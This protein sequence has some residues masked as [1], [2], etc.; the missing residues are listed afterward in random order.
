MFHYIN[1]NN[2]LYLMYNITCIFPSPVWNGKHNSFWK[3]HLGLF[4]FNPEE[5]RKTCFI[6]L[7]NRYA[8]SLYMVTADHRRVW[9]K[10]AC[11]LVVFYPP[12]SVVGCLEKNPP[13]NLQSDHACD[14]T[15]LECRQSTVWNLN[16]L[17]YLNELHLYQILREIKNS[18]FSWLEFKM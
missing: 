17:W 9:K 8:F 12:S 11:S 4:P 10:R 3:L 13:Q 14:T 16:I 5:K 1:L 15:A 6:F 2:Q 7:C 18:D